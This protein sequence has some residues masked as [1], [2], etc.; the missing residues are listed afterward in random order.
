MNIDEQKLNNPTNTI[1]AGHCATSLYGIQKINAVN[2]EN[3]AYVIN[4][5]KMLITKITMFLIMYVDF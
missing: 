5:L 4:A 3:S 2:P 1:V